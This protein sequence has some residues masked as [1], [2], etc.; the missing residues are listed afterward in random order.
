MVDIR[1][2]IV[3]FMIMLVA[4][5]SI[6]FRIRHVGV[7]STVALFSSLR[8]SG[9]FLQSSI[10]TIMQECRHQRN[11][12]LLVS[13]IDD[14]VE[15][16]KSISP[17]LLTSMITSLGE[18]GQLG[19]AISLIAMWRSRGLQPNERH[20]AALITAAKRAGQWELALG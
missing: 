4:L 13:Y 15:S 5:T 20:F 17:S 19:K 10:G 9:N 7:K 11:Y 2:N 1:R 12:E 14:Y 8:S 6:S 16:R 3:V 18:A